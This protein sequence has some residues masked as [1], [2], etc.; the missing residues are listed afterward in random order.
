MF[1]SKTLLSILASTVLTATGLPAA[2]APAPATVETVA[3]FTGAMPTGVTVAPNGRI[4]VNF[5]RWGD[6]VRYSVGEVKADGSV[7]PYPNAAYNTPDDAHP[8]AHLISVQ[9]VV[10][11]ARNRLWI[12]DTAAP[13]FGAP[14][15]GGA[16]LVA[17]D[18]AT[19]TVVKTIVIT[20]PA[21][22]PSTYLNDVRFDLRQGKAGVAYITD[23]SNAGI[24]GIIV[25]DLDS[26]TA[27]RRLS[28]TPVTNPD[29]GFVARADGKPLVRH[30]G[31]GSQGRLD[32]AS[33]G[34][35]LSPDGATLYVAPLTS[36]HVYTVPTALLRDPTVDE[37][38]LL[39]AVKDLGARP[40]ASDGLEMD[41][42]GTLYAGDYEHDALIALGKDGTWRTLAQGPEISWPDTLSIG[43]DHRLYVIANQLHRQAGF[44]DG[45]DLRR[46]PY[47]LLRIKVDGGPVALK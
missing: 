47:H 14:K 6:D 3:S 44:N 9:S 11:D 25:V 26:G 20:A 21:L 43:P 35:A 33:D 38:A 18:L 37:A 30:P 34:I 1:R 29:S 15:E 46:Q 31:D 27:I 19:D 45:K 23:S 8:A 41:D 16:K 12:L 17:V 39:A 28:N 13:G 22:L 24:G 32:I 4:F 36:R 2:A 40:G 5:P 10:A 7:T 42:K